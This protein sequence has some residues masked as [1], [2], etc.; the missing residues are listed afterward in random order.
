MKKYCKNCIYES[1]P[2]KVKTFSPKELLFLEG[3]SLD[4]V[5]RIID[6]LV[7]ITRI[8]PSGDE[9]IFDI[10][11]PGDYIALIAVLQNN[12]SY[13]ASAESLTEVK[14]VKINT[15]D[16]KKAYQSNTIFQSTCLNCAVTRSTMFQNKLF[17]TSNIDTEEKILGTLQILA[18]KFGTIEN[19]TVILKLPITKTVLA[20]VIG[21][22]RETLSR[23][24]T[25]MQNNNIIEIENN[26]YKFD[27]L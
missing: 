11:G 2:H 16:I 13:V 3:D 21:I 27:R 9:K 10:L 7:K 19:D 17:Q 5:Y 25:E 14:S 1:L 24:L 6:G 26:I 23:K 4:F 12:T 20:S 18:Q 22:R 15:L 8:H